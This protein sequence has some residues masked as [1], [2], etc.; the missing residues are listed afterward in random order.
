M[1]K[2]DY[3]E[4]LGISREASEADIKKA[5]HKL[6]LKWHPDLYA[7]KTE[8][9]K[10]AAEEKFKEI[11]EAYSVLSDP[12]KRKSYDQFGH[13]GEGFQTAGGGFEGFGEGSSSIF[14]E[15]FKGFFG[16]DYFQQKNTRTAGE[17][18]A[19]KGEDI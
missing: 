15:I 18:Q 16:G 17:Q 3:Y 11:G 4:V 1:A 14:E 2:K 13:A 7:N 19:R 6:A 10:K 8:K 9:E 5:Y 12:P